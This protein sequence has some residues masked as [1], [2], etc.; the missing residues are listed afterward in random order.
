MVALGEL[1][2][3]RG[4][5]LAAVLL[6]ELSEAGSDQG[7]AEAL[8]RLLPYQSSEHL[9][10]L[11][12]QLESMADAQGSA[13]LRRNAWAALVIADESFD[14]CWTRA[15]KSKSSLADLLDGVPRI[16][17]A[18]VRAKAYDKVLPLLTA[19]DAGEAVR[20]AAIRALV[21]MNHEPEPV[22]TALTELI[23]KGESVQAAA[24]GIA[25]L[26]RGA[27][28]RNQAGQA[29]VGLVAWAKKV[30]AGERTAQEYSEIVQLSGDL[31]GLLP[32]D[33]AAALRKDLKD[34]RVAAFVIRAVREQM[35][36]D[37]PRLV[38]EAGKPFEILFENADFM[39]HNLVLVKPHSD[40]KIGVAAAAMKV[41][42]LDDHGRAY[43][44]RSP[45]VVAATKLLQTG[46]RQTLKL[47]APKEESE[48]VY[49]CTFPGHYQVMRGQWV[50]T[51]DVDAYLQA[52]PEAPLPPP[53]AAGGSEER[54]HD[55]SH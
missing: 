21:S 47:T 45:D 38:V 54:A 31:A 40:E 28:P 22:F 26:P 7:S 19:A 17:D 16:T 29:A 15:A 34:L 12:P 39:P 14:R 24:R 18:S 42:D 8:A 25:G 4:T 36:Y 3:A 33:Q 51:R 23:S 32:A 52:H 43:V 6:G 44:P 49:F 35:R 30:P 11:R 13:E 46:Q 5:N 53:A 37:T 41:E 2:Q 1:A 48:S 9:R 20:P 27:W 10:P 55:H 50:V